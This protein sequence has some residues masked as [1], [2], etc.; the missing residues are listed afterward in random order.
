MKKKLLIC[1]VFITIIFTILVQAQDPTDFYM[2]DDLTI[3]LTISTLINI[4][5]EQEDSSIKYIN[6]QLNIFPKETETQEILSFTTKPNSTNNNNTLL[7]NWNNPVEE[8]LD[9]T[10][11]SRV[12]R[13]AKYTEVKEKVDFP[14][15]D[16]DEDIQEYLEETRMIDYSNPDIKALATELASGED[17]AYVV[18]VKIA[19]W[20]QQ[21][22][23]YSITTLTSEASQSASWVLESRY[24]VCDELTNLYIALLRSVGIPARFVTG[25]SYTSSDLF[26]EPWNLHGWTE[27]YFPDYGWIPFDVT[28][29]QYGFVDPTHIKF[30][31][32]TD[33]E[34][35]SIS[36]EWKGKD[37]FVDMDDPEF[38]TEVVSY[39]KKAKEPIEL[40][41]EIYKEELGFGSYNFIS[42]VIQNTEEFY[43]P[44]HLYLAVP[45]EINTFEFTEKTILLKPNEKKTV[46]WIMQVNENLDEHYEYTFSPKVYTLR[47]I[48]VESKFSASSKKAVLDK[49]VI[50]GII[51]KQIE[52]ETKT[53]S[54]DVELNCEIAENIFYPDKKPNIECILKNKGNTLQELTV[55]FEEQ[56]NEIS[57]GIA[58]K[59][60]IIFSITNDES[61]EFIG[62]VE[63]ENIDLTKISEFEYS[64]LDEP[65]II[66]KYL[67]YQEETT[68]N[69]MMPLKFVIDKASFQTPQNVTLKIKYGNTE[70]WL[71]IEHLEHEAQIEQLINTGE[72]RKELTPIT[73]SIEYEDLFGNTWQEEKKVEVKLL[74]L[75]L[76]QKTKLFFL[77]MLGF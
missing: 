50:E 3:D 40:S 28:Y 60:E 8:T 9:F 65:R 61:G 5:K 14:I 56:C 73:I 75:S 53:Y 16:L 38:D 69:T 66:I 64:I 47:N 55:C 13:Y 72:F 48:S 68:F 58:E 43:M 71:N 24:G 54:K 46:F 62:I 34:Q 31:H 19:D 18:A 67:D 10:V 22:I 74:D 59:K 49:E 29:G 27:V 23:S 45:S 33:S 15:L 42:V 52:E 63:A 7:F 4:E 20:V 32:A 6:A 26:S 36:Y 12:K 30:S 17:D 44:V 1:T 41:A 39:G 25:I 51:E 76:W 70:R 37:V 11:N 21:N 2:Y 57:L 35:A 77:G